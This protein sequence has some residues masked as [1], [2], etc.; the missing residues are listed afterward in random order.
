MNC[1][2]I[3]SLTYWTQLSRRGHRLPSGCELLSDCIFDL[4]NTTTWGRAASANVLWI[5]F[6]L[7][8]WPIEH[9]W[10]VVKPHCP[11]VVNCFQIVSLTYWTQ[12]ARACPACP[13]C[14]E[15][16]SDCIFDLLNTTVKYY[17]TK[18]SLLWIAFRLYLW[19]IEHNQ[20]Y[21]RQYQDGVVNC[22]QIVSLT[23]WTQRTVH[24]Q[25]VCQFFRSVFRK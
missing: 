5:A 24:H 12:L 8:L 3:V 25:I 22:F 21:R 20:W 16:L 15:L 11:L 13:D 9:N 19:P 18:E 7:Y 6:R 10:I 23:Y 14:C 17:K 4:L 2:Q 1:F